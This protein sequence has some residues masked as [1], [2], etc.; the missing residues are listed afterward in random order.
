M[1]IGHLPAGYLIT[2]RCIQR[3]SL[4][5]RATRAFM[6]AGLTG[7][8]APDFDLIWC[9]LVD[10]GQRHH[11]LYP[12]H[13]PLIWFAALL[14]LLLWAG[15]AKNKRPALLCVVFCINGIAHLL[16]DTLVG[17]IGWLMPFDSR[18]FALAHVPARYH[19]WWLNFFLHWS[20][21]LEMALVVAAIGLWRRRRKASLIEA[22]VE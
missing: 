11:H 4:S 18:L 5:E 1:F 14:L 22:P 6:L 15:Y 20:F 12:T 17:D 7:A 10:H 16:L 9:Y 3:L 21:M 8:I 13:W 2:C 19:P